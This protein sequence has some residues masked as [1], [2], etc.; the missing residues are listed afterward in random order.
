MS[1]ITFFDD[2]EPRSETT[3]HD[4]L[5]EEDRFDETERPEE[6]KTKEQEEK[7]HSKSDLRLRQLAPNDEKLYL[8]LEN[9][10]LADPKTQIPNFGGDSDSLIEKGDEAR[11]RGN[12]MMARANYETA[13]KIAIFK[14][15]RDRAIRFLALAEE[16]T[17]TE[18]TKHSEL[19]KTI[20]AN[21]DKVLR[22]SKEYYRSTHLTE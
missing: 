10:L 7:G 4:Q 5:A 12:K 3:K 13:A 18:D 16:V 19:H 11:S 22:I 8:A 20:L 14:Q 2:D 9:F 21:M 15:N 1:G 17:E 6:I